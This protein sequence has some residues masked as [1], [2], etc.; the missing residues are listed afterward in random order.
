[1]AKGSRLRTSASVIQESE[2]L[3]G[4]VK[5]LGVRL[6]VKTIKKLKVMAIEGDTTV[7]ALVKQILEDYTN[8][9]R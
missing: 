1:M 5:M 2:S 9:G 8:T 7:N 3:D 6:K 4:L